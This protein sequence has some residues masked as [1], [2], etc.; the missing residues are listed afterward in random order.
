MLR[1]VLFLEIAGFLSLAISVAVVIMVVLMH[2]TDPSVLIFPFS[3]LAI[4][5]FFVVLTINYMRKD[6]HKIHELHHKFIYKA[7]RFVVYLFGSA[8]VLYALYLFATEK[9]FWSDIPVVVVSIVSVIVGVFSIYYTATLGYLIEHEHLHHKGISF[10]D[11][12]VIVILPIA[13]SAFS[14]MMMFGKKANTTTEGEADFNTTSL[15]IIREFEMSDSIARNKYIGKSVK[16]GGMITEVSGDSAVLLKLATG[17][18]DYTA[19]CGFDKSVYES[20]KNVK[21]G[22]SVIIQCSCSGITSPEGEM[23]LLSEKSLD[24][25]RCKLL[26][27][28]TAKP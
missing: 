12:F 13:V 8:L 20:V 25:I 21:T 11:L 23:D 19:N 15:E 4:T 9:E 5:G 14:V 26:E 24:M 7:G 3:G 16:F 6:L 2:A 22:D 1:K 17:N 10:S 28:K 27:I 18:E